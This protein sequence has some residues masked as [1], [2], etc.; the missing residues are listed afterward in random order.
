MCAPISDI[1]D[2]YIT[3]YSQKIPLS[4]SQISTRMQT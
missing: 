3:I 4:T 2:I 1:I